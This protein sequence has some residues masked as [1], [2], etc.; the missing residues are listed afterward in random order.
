M[1][2]VEINL[3]LE[4]LLQDSMHIAWVFLLLTSCIVSTPNYITVCTVGCKEYSSVTVFLFASLPSGFSSWL[5]SRLCPVAMYK[6]S[7]YNRLFCMETSIER[8]AS[9]VSAWNNYDNWRKKAILECI[10]EKTLPMLPWQYKWLL[11][12]LEWLGWNIIPRHDKQ[13]G[14]SIAMSM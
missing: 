13:Q 12:I 11:W 7:P 2:T 3:L 1:N 4:H 6:Q 8:F 5:A 10:R 14:P 9:L